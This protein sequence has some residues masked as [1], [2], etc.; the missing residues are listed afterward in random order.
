MTVSNDNGPAEPVEILLAEDEPSDAD[1]CMRALKRKNVA[2]HVAWVK[3][4]AEALD[5]LF[6]RGPYARRA[7]AG[8]PR[9]L[10]LDIKMPKVDGF[11]V[12]RQLR[13]DE[14]LATMPVVIMTS[15]D[16]ERDIVL[17]YHL[18]V[19]SYVPK[20]VDFTSFQQAVEEVGL[21]WMLLN[22]APGAT[23]VP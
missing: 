11:E 9:L 10:L 4:G 12:L 8:R 6:A 23:A 3:D 2:N 16:E 22:K 18:G 1:L 15:S 20:P 14:R 7:H 21:Y 5:F 19:N 13:A 17:G